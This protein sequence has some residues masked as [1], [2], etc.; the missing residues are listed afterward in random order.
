MTLGDDPVDEAGTHIARVYNALLGG[1]DNYAG[2]REVVEQFTTAAPEFASL[3]HDNRQFLM[4]TTRF[5]AGEAGINQ[6]L[7]FGAC[8]PVGENMHEIVQRLNGDASVIYI[9]MDPLVLA[10]GRAL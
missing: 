3:A 1:K 4:R 10:H 5:L 2:D 6:F 9:G 8:L 7:D